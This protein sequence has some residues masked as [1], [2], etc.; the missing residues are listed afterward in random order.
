MIKGIFQLE[1]DVAARAGQF[2]IMREDNRI[3]VVSRED[4]EALFNATP[5]AVEAPREKAPYYKSA[6]SLERAQ[7]RGRHMAAIRKQQ[8]EAKKAR[9]AVAAE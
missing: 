4:L 9:L 2:L 8:L 5:A 3:H 1:N 7:A 6:E